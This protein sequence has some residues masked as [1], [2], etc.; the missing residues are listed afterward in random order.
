[1]K[2]KRVVASSV[3]R[4]RASFLLPLL[5][6]LLPLVASAFAL[7]RRRRDRGRGPR[8]AGSGSRS[9]EAARP[10]RA[11]PVGP[12][13]R[14]TETHPPLAAN[15]R[16]RRRRR[17]RQS[18]K[19][20]PRRPPGRHP[21]SPRTRGARARVP[22]HGGRGEVASALPGHRE[23][24]VVFPAAC[25]HA[26]VA[27][28]FTTRSALAT[29]SC[30][31]PGSAHLACQMPQ[32]AR[33]PAVVLWDAAQQTVR[34]NSA[35]TSSEASSAPLADARAGGREC[36]RGARSGTAGTPPSPASPARCARASQTLPA[37][38]ALVL[39]G[40]VLADGLELVGGVRG[41]ARLAHFR[42][43]RQRVAGTPAAAPPPRRARVSRR[44]T[45]PA[46]CSCP[47][48]YVPAFS[49]C[50]GPPGLR[51]PTTARALPS[52]AR[53]DARASSAI[54]S[55]VAGAIETPPWSAPGTR[56]PSR[57]CNSS[58]ALGACAAADA[59]EPAR[60]SRRAPLAYSRD[61]GRC[62]ILPRDAPRRG[63]REAHPRPFRC[64]ALRW[65]CAHRPRSRVLLPT[66]A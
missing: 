48:P 45:S 54:R 51:D 57:R 27:A 60:G 1:M 7:R 26:R 34:A 3:A 31:L 14:R 49:S 5:L 13:R 43:R 4:V 28:A 20:S 61:A 21:C 23:G 50:I 62:F 29:Y 33:E 32:L 63:H 10:A 59:W 66:H 30:V 42:S 37:R 56:A 38:A 55:S 15:A 22:A 35:T 64:P 8:V 53:A 19:R 11:G 9:S 18:P 39:H 65:S 47:R 12:R 16:R 2:K 24:W 52:G 17:R 25:A 6:L 44:P 58:A 46:P 40:Q 41:V 36:I